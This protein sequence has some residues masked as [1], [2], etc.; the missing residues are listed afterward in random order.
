MG[1]PMITTEEV[2]FLVRVGSWSECDLESWVES[3]MIDGVDRA[4]EDGI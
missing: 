3:R 1:I 2:Y 4:L